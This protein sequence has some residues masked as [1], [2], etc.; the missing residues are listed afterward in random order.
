MIIAE[1]PDIM[2]LQETKCATEDM[3]K[4]LPCCWKQGKGIYMAAMGT[5]RGSGSTLESK[6]SHFG[7]KIH[8]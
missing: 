2:M 4:L 1:K 3:D 7:K 6:L 8:N 5:A